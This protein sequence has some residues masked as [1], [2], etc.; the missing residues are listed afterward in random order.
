[1]NSNNAFGRCLGAPYQSSP[2]AEIRQREGIGSMIL[3][4]IDEPIE[5]K[6]N[7]PLLCG[8]K[9]TQTNESV[10]R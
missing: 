1:M 10:K 3:I 2:L 9:V 8:N 6:I 4:V 5:Y 7:T